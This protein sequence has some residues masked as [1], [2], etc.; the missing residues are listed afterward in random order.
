MNCTLTQRVK[1]LEHEG[2]V[3]HIGALMKDAGY[4]KAFLVCDRGIVNLGL[5][6]LIERRL[7]AEGLGCVLYD[8]VQPDPPA[9]LVDTG[10]EICRSEQC[11]CVI[12]VGGGSSIDTAKGINI[13]RFNPGKIL[14]YA[15][16][17][18]AMA[19]SPGLITV[20]TTAGTGSELSNGLIISDTERSA[21]VPILAQAGMSE[22]AVLDA[23]LT[24][25]MPPGL[26]MSTGLDVFSHACEAYTSV[27]ACTTTD[28]IC[29][30]IMQEVIEWLPRAMKDGTDSEAR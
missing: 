24:A 11:D 2:A 30:K 26:T 5:A 20:P 1:I 21:K 27:Q 12:A 13:L 23:S 7:D 9:E 19:P 6:S 18:C 29:E 17:S 3:Q 8:R 25:G 14:E 4:H 15:D 22:Y 16:M 10:A 28:L